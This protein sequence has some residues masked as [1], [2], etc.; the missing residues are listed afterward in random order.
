MP[1]KGSQ[2]ERDLCRTLSLWWS[3]DEHDDLFWRTSQSGG[4]ATV[5]GR[6]GKTTTGHCGDI[7]ATDAQGAPLLQVV[8][9]EAK[10]GYP[11]DTFQ[12]IIDWK[13]GAKKPVY[14]AWAKQA[15]A[16]AK[17]ASSLTWMVIH[18]RDRRK[19]VVLAPAEL[20]GTLIDVASCFVYGTMYDP[21]NGLGVCSLDQFLED[22]HPLDVKAVWRKLCQKATH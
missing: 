7:G 18:R 17:L 12:D 2:F 16:A 19:E 20:F 6:K 3:R 21:V 11:T 14:L 10:R 13:P 4:R 15:S 22:V 5:R 9:I 8:S 1:A